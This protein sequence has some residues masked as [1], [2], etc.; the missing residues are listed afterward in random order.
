MA[1]KLIFTTDSTKAGYTFKEYKNWLI[2]SGNIS[3]EE[4]PAR[5]DEDFYRWANDGVDEDFLC[6]MENIT[7]SDYNTAC[8]ITGS[9]GLWY[10]RREIA[11]TPCN[12]LYNAINKCI[13]GQDDFEIYIDGNAIYV[14]SYN[15]DSQYHGGNEFKIVIRGKKIKKDFPF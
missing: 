15:H 13:N 8:Y 4:M 2:E 10:G 5:E 7:Y 12:T 14:N 1:K 3:F 9:V 11:K 6:L